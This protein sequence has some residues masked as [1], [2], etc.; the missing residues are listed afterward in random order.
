MFE[1]FAIVELF[2]HTRIAGKCTE[3]VI[4]GGTF[5]RVDVPKTEREE[6]FTKFYGSSAIYSITP[7]DEETMK[8]AVEGY[9]VAPIERWRLAEKHPALAAGPADDDYYDDYPDDDGPDDDPHSHEEKN[10]I[11]PRSTNDI[12][13]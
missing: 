12:P 3:Q 8:K 13:F 4:A 5:L 7:T 10:M 9:Q 6:A 11:D 2:G 1:A